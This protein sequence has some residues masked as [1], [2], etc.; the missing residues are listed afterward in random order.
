MSE[1]RGLSVDE[2]GYKTS[3]AAA[4]LA[5]QGI[6]GNAEDRI[7]L[8][9][10]AINELQQKGF[11]ATNDAPKYSYAAASDAPDAEYKLEGCQGKI[12]AIR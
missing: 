8:D 10:H 9:V 7:A 4:V 5:S 6:S 12:V 3:K 11:A 2:D 1:E